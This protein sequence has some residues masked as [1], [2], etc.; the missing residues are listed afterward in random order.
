MTYFISVFN[1]K[2]GVAKTTT[3]L[4]LGG[5]LVEMGRT[6]LL[7]DLDPQANLTASLTLL[8]RS[9]T[10]TVSDVLEGKAT[11]LNASQRTTVMGLNILPAN[12]SLALLDRALYQSEAYEVR[13][14]NAVSELNPALY[15]YVLIDCPPSL[16]PLTL[17][18]LTV[19][20]LMIIP[21]QAEYYALKS[22]ENVFVLVN[23]TRRRTNPGLRYR[24]LVTMYDRRNA[25]SGRMLER[26]HDTYD[27]AL[28]NTVI[29]VDTK[30]R[31]G[32]LQGK[33]IT[34]YSPSTRAAQQ[35]R[36]LAK[37][38]MEYE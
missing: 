28:F 26:M 31:E 38:V 16:G 10:C 25:I 8:P 7:V 20:N 22:L 17:N 13:L 9:L 23:L 21:T 15:D 6:V 2:G 32:P 37:E 11:L 4:S 3:C 19:A 36:A 27:N 35:Y 30:L 33:P 14:K 5:C 34:V 24:V 12:A 1:Q 18:A 29:D